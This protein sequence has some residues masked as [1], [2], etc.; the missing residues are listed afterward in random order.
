LFLSSLF[1]KAQ[2]FPCR[3]QKPLLVFF[4]ISS[5]N[6]AKNASYENLTRLAVNGRIEFVKFFY[7]NGIGKNCSCRMARML[8]KIKQIN[9]VA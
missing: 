7:E 6:R 9:G 5:I 1:F 2:R 3:L 4:L 8:S